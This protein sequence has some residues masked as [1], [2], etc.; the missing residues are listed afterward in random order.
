MTPFLR[1]VLTALALAALAVGPAAAHPHVWV[2]MTSQLVYAPDGSVTG[3]RHAWTF[4]EMFSTFATQ[5]IE[6]KKKGEFSR[7]ELAPLAEVN[8]TSLKEYDYFTKA[9]A[10]GKTAKLQEPV[11]YWLDYKDAALTLHFTLPFK[12]PVK[13]Q[14]LDLEVYDPTWFV[15]FGFADKDP[16]AL[17]G[18]PA[19][20]ALTVHRPQDV[21]VSQQ[22]LSE[23]FF[24]QLN[25]GSA[26][27]AQFANKISVKCP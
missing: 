13:A 6:T 26:F 11:D 3:V 16:V 17:V 24:D 15:D 22:R 1:T 7:E 18:A 19:Q 8:V 12:A 9:K 23:S 2:K 20:C 5:G 4:D 21:N 25:A 27:G 10:N 14:S